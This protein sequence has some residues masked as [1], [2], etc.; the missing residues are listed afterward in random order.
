MLL[1]LHWEFVEVFTSLRFQ[2][3]FL[4]G[5]NLSCDSIKTDGGDTKLRALNVIYLEQLNKALN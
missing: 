3:E 1:Q 2:L 4:K 5:D